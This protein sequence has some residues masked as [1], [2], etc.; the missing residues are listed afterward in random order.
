LEALFQKYKARGV[1]VLV[2]DV[3]ESKSTGAGWVKQMKY[4]LPVLLD[5]E[6]KTS[7]AYAPP[8]AQPDLARDQVPIASNL[9]IG[10][11]GKILFYSLLDSANFDAKLRA[12]TSRLDQLLA[13][14]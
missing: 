4:T 12:L 6:G 9:I 8:G 14:K 10:Q 11:D 2:I 13:A 5:A 3:K 1:Q 7:S